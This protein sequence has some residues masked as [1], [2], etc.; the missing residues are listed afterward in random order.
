MGKRGELG[1][2]YGNISPRL[3]PTK[4]PS[5]LD[6]AWAAGVYEGEGSICEPTPTASAR[7]AVAQKDTE[8][9][10]RLRDW[11]G[12]SVLRHCGRSPKPDQVCYKW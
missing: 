4:V 10:Y 8:I 1:G 12:G 6:I 5:E 3:E 2:N 9:L 11:F 7:I